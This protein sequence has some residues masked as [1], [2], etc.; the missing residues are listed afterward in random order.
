MTARSVIRSF[1]AAG[2]FSLGLLDGLRI[3]L[4]RPHVRAAPAGFGLK[5]LAK[6]VMNIPG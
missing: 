2:R 5:R 3:R 4:R 1:C 6:V